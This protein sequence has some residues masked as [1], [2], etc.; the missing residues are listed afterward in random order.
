MTRGRLK[1][2]KQRAHAKMRC[3]ERYG[4]SLKKS[5][6]KE[7]VKIIISNKAKFIRRQS[8]NVTRWIVNYKG[9]DLKCIYDK[10]RKTI[11]TFL[12]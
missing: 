9:Q 8:N 3:K 10:R 11:R 5:E 6:Q 7:I 12:S 4:L 1:T 2:I